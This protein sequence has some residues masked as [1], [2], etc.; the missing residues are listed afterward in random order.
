MKYRYPKANRAG[1][2]CGQE[3]RG[4]WA[5]RYMI[6]QAFRIHHAITRTSIPQLLIFMNKSFYWL[7]LPSRASRGNAGWWWD[8][9][10]SDICQCVFFFRF[11]SHNF[12]SLHFL[13]LQFF[14]LSAC[15]FCLIL[16]DL[17]KILFDLRAFLPFG[18]IFFLADWQFR[19]TLSWAVFCNIR[20]F[21]Q[22]WGAFWHLFQTSSL[23]ARFP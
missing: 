23:Q 15:F 7:W 8:V 3:S 17:I 14:V 2:K 11:L 19:C 12:C 16:F 4:T 21:E 5:I 13:F 20:C 22:L 1:Q 9:C 6:G 18:Q 10:R